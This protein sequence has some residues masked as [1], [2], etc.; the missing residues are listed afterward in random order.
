[1]KRRCRP[2]KILG[3]TPL[4]ETVKR[5]RDKKSRKGFKRP[6]LST[7]GL[8]SAIWMTCGRRRLRVQQQ[9]MRG[10]SR[11]TWLWINSTMETQQRIPLQSLDPMKFVKCVFSWRRPEV[12]LWNKS[13]S[14]SSSFKNL[15]NKR[16]WTPFSRKE[17]KNKSGMRLIFSHQEISLSNAKPNQ[18]PKLRFLNTA[19]L[20][21]LPFQLATVIWRTKRAFRAKLMHLIRGTRRWKGI[22]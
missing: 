20:K 16:R 11:N 15:N 18:F 22:I 19:S 13:L 8:K 6:H 12:R 21:K 10:L 5:T 14:F 7:W 17:F 3:K 9:K 2:T 4:K 1:M